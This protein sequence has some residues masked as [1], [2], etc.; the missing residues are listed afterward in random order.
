M[1]VLGMEGATPTEQ[2]AAMALLRQATQENKEVI[3]RQ[4]CTLRPLALHC[5]PCCCQ[6]TTDADVQ[7]NAAAA[8]VN[9]S[10][11]PDNKAR[12]VRSGAVSRRSWSCSAGPDGGAVPCRRHHVDCSIAVEDE[13]RAAFGVLVVRAGAGMSR[14]S[15]RF[16]GLPLASGFEAAL[17]VVAEGDGP[18]AVWDRAFLR[19]SRC[20]GH[21]AEVGAATD[22]PGGPWAGVA[23]QSC[24]RLTAHTGETLPCIR[25]VLVPARGV[26]DQRARAVVP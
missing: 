21:G 1:P 26:N 14:G 20:Q 17:Q 3:R 13:N 15:M 12:I 2:A 18:T 24:S 16:R 19:L 6:P 25:L 11:E 8:L 23:G 9:L 7:V 10:L 4:L 5:T 22:S